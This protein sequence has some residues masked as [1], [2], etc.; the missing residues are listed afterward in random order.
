MDDYIHI[1]KYIKM[2]LILED[3]IKEIR[4]RLTYTILTFVSSFMSSYLYSYEILYLSCRY[5]NRSLIFTSLSESFLSQIKFA[6]FVSL[7]ITLP[8]VI[9]HAWSFIKPGLYKFESVFYSRL[10]IFSLLLYIVSYIISSS[11][12]LPVAVNFLVTFEF[13]SNHS[14]TLEL[15][16]KISHY[17]SFIVTIITSSIVFFQLPVILFLLQHLEWINTSFMIKN[18]KYFIL[19]TFIL[20]TI[21]SPPDLGSQF[22]LA[23]PSIAFY[24]FTII[25]F[26]YQDEKVLLK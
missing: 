15:Y 11:M 1:K 10:L 13:T 25:C 12:L 24:E 6:T 16:P 4:Y 20:A 21:F 26:L 7:I 17:L 5:L 9:Y 8:F 3:H 19:M 22:L 2:H 14:F 23:L 18:R